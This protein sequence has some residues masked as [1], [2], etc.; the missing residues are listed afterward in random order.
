MTRKD[1]A[2]AFLTTVTVGLLVTQSQQHKPQPLLIHAGAP[3][4]CVPP[5]SH[6]QWKQRRIA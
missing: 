5:A 1:F 3:I 4:I 2:L 6:Y